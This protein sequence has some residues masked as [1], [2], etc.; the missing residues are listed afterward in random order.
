MDAKRF[1]TLA[2]SLTFSS[3]RGVLAGL[4]GSLVISAVAELD[5]QAKRRARQGQQRATERNKQGAGRDRVG[6]EK[7]KPCPPC[8][9]RKKGKCKG[10][11]PDGTGCSGGTC[12]GGRCVA[13][14][15]PPSPAPCPEGQR[16]CRGACLSVLICCDA[17]DCAG[18]RTC[19]AGTC[20]CPPEKSKLCPGSTICKECCVK[21]DCTPFVT[22]TDT[23]VATCSGDGVCVCAEP[24]TRY[25]A[26]R[27]HCG[28][29]CESTECTGGA[30]CNNFN[31]DH[32]RCQC[33][34]SEDACVA[35]GRTGCVAAT[36]ECNTGC[37]VLCN[38]TFASPCPCGAD[39][40]C[41]PDPGT[42]DY[43]CAPI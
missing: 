24:G 33:L 15:V 21:A 2:K 14:V 8:K 37:G 23:G 12:Q 39:L 13:A 4:L 42:S 5:A 27:R 34:A 16:L 29:C 25:C 18:G 19:Q 26:D 11:L 30:I 38:P 6:A 28:S 17:S 35:A 20:A 43:R 1:D 7:K 9:K 40:A 41:F 36:T 10:T 3:R 22:Q 31:S 32:R